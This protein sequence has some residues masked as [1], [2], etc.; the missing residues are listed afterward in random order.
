MKLLEAIAAAAIIVLPIAAAAPSTQCGSSPLLHDTVS[1]E[2]RARTLLDRGAACVRE[3]KPLQSISIFSELIGL[4]PNNT[5]AYLNRGNAYLQ[6]GQFQLG[7]A[8]FS[9]IISVEPKM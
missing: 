1:K 8:D 2:L 7:I 5:V 9:H 3:G 4:Q 6:T